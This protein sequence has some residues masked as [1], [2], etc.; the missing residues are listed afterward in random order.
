MAISDTLSDPSQ[1]SKKNT[2]IAL[3]LLRYVY[4]ILKRVNN[5]RPKKVKILILH[6]K[7]YPGGPGMASEIGSSSL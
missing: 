4:V 2:D 7:K 5:V 1:I 3:Y 6:P